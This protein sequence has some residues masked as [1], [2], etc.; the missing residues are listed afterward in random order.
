[1]YDCLVAWGW[2]SGLAE[3]VAAYEALAGWQRP[4]YV[5]A[6]VARDYRDLGQYDKALALYEVGRQQYPQDLNFG[7]GEIL[8]LADAKR[9]EEAIERGNALLVAS[10]D[11][12][13]LLS[14]LL[15]ALQMT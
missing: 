8:T 11:D 15:Y 12:P 9:A 13:E 3:A 2:A 6:A 10:P 14:A 7:Y 1:M 4:A 5:D